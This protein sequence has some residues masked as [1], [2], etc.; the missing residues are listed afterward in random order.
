MDQV[1]IITAFFSG[2]LTFFAPCTFVSLPAFI[3]YISAE[4]FTGT[5]VDQRTRKKRILYSA[6]AYTTGFTIVF[7]TLG[8]TATAIGR[9]VLTNKDALQRIGGFLMMTAGTFMLFGHKFRFLD[10]AFSEKKLKVKNIDKKKLLFPFLIGVTSALAWTPCVGPVLGSI[11]FLAGASSKTP[12][13]G[14]ILLL[15]HS[16][17]IS[18]PFII[19]SLV[20]ERSMSL[21]KRIGKYTRMI[22]AISGYMIIFFGAALLFGFYGDISSW[23][24]RIFMDLGYTPR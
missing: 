3:S 10:F 11:L 17:G 6:L 5:E 19:F 24:H 12:L 20:F 9:S 18:I 7:T 15:I 2:L 13:H 16:M 4:T 14:A 23:V 8:L 1:T 21:I 22:Y